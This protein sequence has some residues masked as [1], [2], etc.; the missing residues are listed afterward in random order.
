M[1]WRWEESRM[2]TRWDESAVMRR[3][4]LRE[5][6]GNWGKRMVKS[7]R[8]DGSLIGEWWEWNEWRAL[9]WRNDESE[10]RGRLCDESIIRG[11][12]RDKFELRAWKGYDIRC[13]LARLVKKHSANWHNI[14]WNHQAYSSPTTLRVKCLSNYC[15]Q[16]AR[17][18]WESFFSFL[19]KS[20]VTYSK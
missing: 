18:I 14:L 5:E 10:I 13:F 7:L 8:E 15:E 6:W 11:R 1:G 9:R 3:Y 20:I 19:T 2:R 16:Y 17:I 4:G 12:L